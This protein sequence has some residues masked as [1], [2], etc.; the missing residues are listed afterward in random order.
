[1]SPLNN[2]EAFD[3]AEV[4]RIMHSKSGTHFDP[5]LLN[6][7]NGIAESLYAEIGHAGEERLTGLLNGLIRR[8]FSGPSPYLP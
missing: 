6:I 4:M 1:M 2:K 3:L 5:H 7:F 8:Y